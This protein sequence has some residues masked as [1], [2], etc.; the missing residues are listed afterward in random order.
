[1]SRYAVIMTANQDDLNRFTFTNKPRF[2][3]K[4]SRLSFCLYEIIKDLYPYRTLKYFG[5]VRVF[6]LNKA[7]L[8]KVRIHMDMIIELL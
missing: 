8:L 3:A 2:I 4:K 1:M 5:A 6:I 7:G